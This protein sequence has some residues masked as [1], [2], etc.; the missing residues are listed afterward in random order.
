MTESH[1]A[2][3]WTRQTVMSSDN[4]D[5]RDGHRARELHQSLDET[6]IA[7]TERTRFDPALHRDI[8]SLY[9][10]ALCIEDTTVN[11]LLQSLAPSFT[12]SWIGGGLSPWDLASLQ[13]YAKLVRGA[14]EEMLAGLTP[15]KLK[16]PVDLSDA[17]LGRPDALWV[18][19]HLCLGPIST[20]RREID[21]THLEDQRAGATPAAPR[22]HHAPAGSDR[23]NGVQKASPAATN[24]G[25][26]TDAPP[27][28]R[29]RSQTL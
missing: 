29:R 13:G 16:A 5:A 1:D 28:R 20:I 2:Q 18:V 14:T 8:V 9:A 19:N 7:A 12:S 25:V 15:A 11:V 3:R 4:R 22:Q 10:H 26:S 24:G 21:I 23:S 6:V 17:G 27:R